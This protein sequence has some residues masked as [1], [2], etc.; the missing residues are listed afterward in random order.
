MANYI[1]FNN[2]SPAPLPELRIKTIRTEPID[3]GCRITVEGEIDSNGAALE[4]WAKR[5]AARGRIIL[6][7]GKVSGG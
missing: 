4:E 1:V 7:E 2:V 6:I 3:G 5:E